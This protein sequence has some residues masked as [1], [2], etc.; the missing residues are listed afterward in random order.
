M[1]KLFQL[2]LLVLLLAIS[3][4]I[5]NTL[6]FSPDEQDIPTAVDINISS[7]VVKHRLANVL[8]FQTISNQDPSL[9]NAE[10]FSAMQ[11][12]LAH[13]FPLLFSS[14]DKEIVNQHSLLFKW[15]GKNTI[16]KPVLLLAHQDVVPVPDE[17]LSSWTHPPFAG[18]IDDK[19]IWGR[20]SLDDKSSLVAIFEAVTYL[21]KDGFQPERTIYLAFG[22]DEEVGGAQ[23]AVKI[24][25]LLTSRNIELA[26]VLDEGGLISDGL[27]SGIEPAVALV[28]IAEKGYVSLELSINQEGGHSSMPPKHTAIGLLSQA[29]VNIEKHPMPADSSQSMMLFKKIAPYM[30]FSKRMIFANTW[31][32]KPLIEQQLGNNKLTNAMIRTT[33]ATTIINAGVKENVLP[34]SAKAIVNFRILPGDSVESIKQHII[35]VIN[36]PLIK[37][38]ETKV[39]REASKVSDPNAESFK[40]LT[41]TIHQSNGSGK[42]IVVAPYLVMG[43]TDSRNFENLSNNIYRFLFNYA[44]PDDVKRIHSIDERISIDNYV[45]VIRFYYQLIKNTDDLS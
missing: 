5:V 43:G 16:L 6:N 14:L 35:T 12:Y 39:G 33:T 40:L 2:L 29:I 3:V 17:N 32:T 41:Q 20:G 9:F 37:V 31:L 34:V 27:L 8:K 18:V 30:S 4:I 45:K 7:E 42:N 44:G 15:Q 38:S 11:E 26:F 24:A 13:T 36:N 28:G 10:A 25:E 1:K 19:Y 21:L 23:G 22:H